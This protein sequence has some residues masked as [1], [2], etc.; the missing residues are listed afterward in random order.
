[1]K[2]LKLYQAVATLLLA[3]CMPV[4]HAQVPK[5]TVK[6][7]ARSA[8]KAIQSVENKAPRVAPIESKPSQGYVVEP[9]PN[10]V[11]SL[12]ERPTATVDSAPLQYRLIDEQ[13]RV[14]D[15]SADYYSRVVRRVNDA[16]GL[17]AA[18][19][20]QIEFDPAY[21]TLALH[22]LELVRSGQRMNRLENS[23]L[24]LLQRETQLERRI[25]D[26]RATLSALLEDVRPGDEI[27]F[28]YSIRGSNPVFGS[29]FVHTTWTGTDKGPTRSYRLRLLSSAERTINIQG[30]NPPFATESTVSSGW[31]ETVVRR[32]GIPQVS[33]EQSS[34]FKSLQAYQ[35]KLSEFSSWQDVAQWGQQ[36]FSIGA[37]LPLVQQQAKSIQASADSKAAQVLAALNFVQ[38][39]IRYFGTEGGVNSHRPADPEKV[40]A[41]R[42]G[43]CKD[44]VALLIALLRELNISATPVIVSTYLRRDVEGM[45]PSPL[46]FD[47][48]I[49]KVDIDG[50]AYWLDGT[51]T[52]QSGAL[53]NRQSRGLGLGLLLTP[54]TTSLAA[55][56]IAYN[57]VR[58]QVID[59]IKVEKFTDDPK[60]ESRVTYFGDLAEL[61]RQVISTN[62]QKDF[63]ADLA[64]PYV[65]IYPKIRTIA[66]MAIEQSSD[67]DAVTF[68][69]QFAIGDFWRFPEER[70]LVADLGHWSLG[71]ALS[72]PKTQK[73][74]NPY[75][76]SFP[77][78]YRQEISLEFPEDVYKQD[79]SA[80]FDD[81]E[82]PISVK[83]KAEY[84]RRKI[85]YV[86]ELRFD[87][88]QIDASNW[89][90]T[91]AKV[92]QYY[93]RLV[94][95]AA[96]SAIP[97]DRMAAVTDEIKAITDNIRAKRLNPKTAVQ[98]DALYKVATLSAQLSGG[99]LPPILE[100]QAL[101]ERGVQ[102]DLQGRFDKA[103][104]DFERAIVLEP[105]SLSILNSAAVNAISR[106]DFSRAIGLTDQILSKDPQ[107][108]TALINRGRSK[109]LSKHLPGSVN[110]F[111]A[112]L[113]D[114]SVAR[115][116]YPLIWLYLA[117]LHDGAD[118][119][120][121]TAQ[122]SDDQLPTEW[123]RPI[124]DL[125][126]GRASEES[127][128]SA[129]K[130]QKSPPNALCE[131]YFYIAEKHLASGDK[132]RARQYWQKAVDQGVTEFV[133]D[134]AAKHRLAEK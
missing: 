30:N 23:Q 53:K 65:R 29:K 102:Y 61:Y 113:S 68:V 16:G 57:T 108:T 123:P 24:R 94:S 116:G 114:S 86:A 91:T 107:N 88:D 40:L 6:Q 15:K 80:R 101:R 110:D 90:S 21:Q 132:S 7:P 63:E 125:M 98:G 128:L 120:K 73:R 131:A 81:K 51:Q 47:H 121:L 14:G 119:S 59:K 32:D 2:N 129:A 104:L 8:E 74:K 71:Q 64:A 46:A 56:P 50:E 75:A 115:T 37:Q 42:F 1:M 9:A 36:Q 87:A 62:G 27:D 95:A 77:G 28:A 54:D 82:G 22:Q 96:I 44:K 20:I 48:V 17:A 118:S 10:W 35:I 130:T 97:I 26:G 70:T 79:S 83:T 127:V 31:R 58:M 55:L 99:R 25:S 103:Q 66:P 124:V 84:G 69:Q 72:F 19:Q 4:V 60:L 67:D 112:A 134:S 39:D 43:D 45:L 41:Q 12:E 18:S 105:T 93:Q 49:A 3:A 117:N 11:A 33:T 5:P 111:K 89:A 34:P 13:I 38:K 85:D 100:A 109:Y 106:G 92:N 76:F 133:E 126:R 78:I 122:Y 52:H